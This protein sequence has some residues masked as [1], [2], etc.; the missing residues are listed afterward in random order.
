[1]FEN[2]PDDIKYNVVINHEEQY[3]IWPS[4]LALPSGWK[5]TGTSG[6]KKEC[7]HSFQE[8]DDYPILEEI[9]LDMAKKARAGLKKG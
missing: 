6:S 2:F 1:M 4:E 7:V 8:L 3:S 9:Q 5:A